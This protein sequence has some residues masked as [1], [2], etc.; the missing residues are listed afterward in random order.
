MAVG[1]FA[2]QKPF[3]KLFNY[4][5]FKEENL[6]TKSFGIGC[7]RDSGFEVGQ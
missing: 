2:H 5:H 7:P 4:H 6:Q 3:A 1:K